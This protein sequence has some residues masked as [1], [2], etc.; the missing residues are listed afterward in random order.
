MAD[1]SLRLRWWLALLE[2]CPSWA[3]EGVWLWLVGRASAASDWSQRAAGEP[4]PPW[5]S[6]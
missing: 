6:P 5:C 4:P 3:P 1:L 2:L